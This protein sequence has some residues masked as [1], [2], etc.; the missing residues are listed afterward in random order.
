MT[1]AL[2]VKYPYG[3]LRQALESLQHAHLQEAVILMSDSRWTFSE[4]QARFEDVG[5]KIFKLDRSTALA[6]AGDVKTGEHCV[7]ELEKKFKKLENNKIKYIDINGTF[8]RVYKY[9]KKRDPNTFRLL[10]L[11][12]KY[13]KSG[14][15]KLIYFESPDF[16]CVFVNGIKGIGDELAYKEVFKIIS[17]KIDDVSM[18]TGDTQKDTMKV[19]MLFSDVMYNIVIKNVEY[20]KV[21][22]PIQFVIIDKSGVNTAELSWTTDGTG[23]SDV[24]HR[25]TARSDEITTYKKRAHLKPNFIDVESFGLHSYCD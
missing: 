5:T 7:K 24:W 25:I 15:V 14:K 3:R 2:G 11:M 22:G 8:K 10:F 9:H 23:K 19:A 21:G 4:P 20:G 1:L 12:G 16:K 6:Y 17:P 18:Y 13:L